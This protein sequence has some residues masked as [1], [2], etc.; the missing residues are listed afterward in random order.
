MLFL[1]NMLAYEILPVGWA[2]MEKAS[3]EGWSCRPF[4]ERVL[5]NNGKSPGFAGET[6]GV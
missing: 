6:V 1:L 4:G 3:H 2:L 5:N